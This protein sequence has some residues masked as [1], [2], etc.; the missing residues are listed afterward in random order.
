MIILVQRFR[1]WLIILAISGFTSNILAQI[2]DTLLLVQFQNDITI[3]GE[4]K[5]HPFDIT[6][7]ID[8]VSAIDFSAASVRYRMDRMVG[9]IASNGENYAQDPSI[10]IRGFGARSAFGTRGIMV[11]QDGIPLTSPDGTTQ[12]DEVSPMDIYIMEVLRGGLGA[13]MGNSAGGAILLRSAPYANEWIFLSSINQFGAHLMGIKYGQTHKKIGIHTSYNFHNFIG[14]RAHSRSEIHTLYNKTL[15]LLDANNKLEFFVNGAFSPLG[16]D[17]GALNGREFSVDRWAAGANNL[18]WNAGEA[19]S[20]L[21]MAIKHT[22]A[23]SQHITLD[24]SIFYR[25]R[26]FEA[27]LPFTRGGWVSLNRNFVGYQSDL[28]YAMRKDV[29]CDFGM[30]VQSQYDKRGRHNNNQGIKGER[31]LLQ[32][33]NLFNTA[34][35]LRFQ[36]GFRHT[37]V[38]SAVRWDLLDFRL[39]D[40]YLTD[41][42]NDGQRTLSALTGNIGI[43]TRFN[44]KIESTFIL[45]NS[46][47]SPTLNELTNNPTLLPGWNLDLKPERAFHTE[48]STKYNPYQKLNIEVAI[49]HIALEGQIVSFGL[50]AT[51]GRTYFANAAKTNRFGI[52]AVA[53]VNILNN[54]YAQVQYIFNH[55]KYVDFLWN[56]AQLSGRKQPLIPTNRVVLSLDYDAY[57]LWKGQLIIK[58]MD[59]IFFNH[60]NTAFENNLLECNAVVSRSF[61][62]I[63]G[64]EL[65]L[66]LQNIGS[67]MQYSHFRPNAIMDQYFEAAAPMHLGIS[68]KY[69]FNKT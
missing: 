66:N 5:F 27:R 46:F 63:K 28:R 33:E 24:H 8:T 6:N 9:V 38:F 22:S 40:L 12:L 30:N 45:S 17:P 65:S 59:K 60:E 34:V 58:F 2:Q 64:L 29:V 11:Y 44:K 25:N 21:G 39:Q 13:F 37:K 53:K 18:T 16:F 35:Y 15:W 57:N 26:D 10:I 69:T 55:Y 62:K 4:K 48:I 51:P 14:K 47:E 3:I 32:N 43:S 61:T 56:G 68:L 67:L 19:V 7:D 52:E 31:T 23:V 49:Y 36:K 41:G 42:Q 54:F 50:P 20:S 1:I